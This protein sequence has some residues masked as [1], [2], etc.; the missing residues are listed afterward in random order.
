MSYLARQDIEIVNMG[1]G[2][3]A[4]SSFFLTFVGSVDLKRMQL[5]PSAFSNNDISIAFLQQNTS[6]G[7]KFWTG[8][9]CTDVKIV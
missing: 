6:G 7:L 4:E 8:R 2:L 5:T 1:V 9:L 3:M